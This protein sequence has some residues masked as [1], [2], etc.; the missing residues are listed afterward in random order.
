VR[1]FTQPY[2]IA[3]EFAQKGNIKE[4]QLA[5]QVLK[6]LNRRA[7]NLWAET[8][9]RAQKLL[10][11]GKRED[12]AKLYEDFARQVAFPEYR[13]KAWEKLRLLRSP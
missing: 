7:E 6:E 2:E 11:E 4:R 5:Q 10:Q 1:V 3:M 9:K 8:D 12:A 13:Q